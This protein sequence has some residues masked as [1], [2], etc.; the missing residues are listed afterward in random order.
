MDVSSYK[1]HL[2]RI[3]AE[4]AS[5]V[6]TSRQS[7]ADSA[8]HVKSSREAIARSLELLGQTIAGRR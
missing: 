5:H 8:A 4:C 7:C 3:G 6:T 1:R 2:A